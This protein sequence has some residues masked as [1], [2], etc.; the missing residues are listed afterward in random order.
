MEPPIPQDHPLCGA[1]RC[2]L[3]PHVAFATAQSMVVRAQMAFENVDLYLQ[4]RPH[5]LMQ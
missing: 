5:N 2:I 4:G 1:P 3:T